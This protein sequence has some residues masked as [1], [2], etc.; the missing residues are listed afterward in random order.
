MDRA[1]CL[2]FFGE[3]T[4]QNHSITTKKNKP[5]ILYYWQCFFD[6]KP[7]GMRWDKIHF[8]KKLKTP[9]PSLAMRC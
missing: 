1:E 2:L 6:K 8:L 9:W 4:H 5:F 3:K 7:K